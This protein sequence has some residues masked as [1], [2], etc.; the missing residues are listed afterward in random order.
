MFQNCR[1][2]LIRGFLDYTC[3]IGR[4]PVELGQTQ[5]SRLS[6]THEGLS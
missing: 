5:G 4:R 6:F 3:L 2:S 1:N